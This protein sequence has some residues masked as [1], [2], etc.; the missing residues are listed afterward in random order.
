MKVLQVIDRLNI[1][2]AERVFVNL[3]KLLVGKGIL[4]DA[5]LFQSGYPL[6]SEISRNSR[7]HI[8]NRKNKYSLLK[9]YKA[10]RICSH[11][12]IVHVHMRHC[13]AYIKLAQRL[14]GGRYKIILHDH[15]GDIEID[16]TI[17]LRL[18]VL[19][20]EYYI[21]V[22]N[23]LLKWG[24]YDLKMQPSHAFLLGNTIQPQNG[25]Y[26]SA[27]PAKKAILVSNLRPTK[28][29]EFAIK[30]FKETGWELDIY[31]NKA[32]EH[33]YQKLTELIGTTD[34]IRIIS[35]V[36]DL[37]SVYDQYT[38]AIHCSRSETGPLVLLEYLAYGVPF[39]AYK[40]G[41]VA[42]IVSKELPQ[43]FMD[44]FEPNEWKKRIEEI[45]EMKALPQKQ[46]AIFNKYFSPDAYVQKC[47]EIYRCVHS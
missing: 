31:G 21:G 25:H 13:F 10:H 30:L 35:N 43:L 40:T 42:E 7:V 8:L 45:I 29:I 2:G 16:K 6:E 22:S 26:A 14:F 38:I 1:G 19:K 11:Y 41:E 3:T 4:V 44:S 47:L 33:Y 46:K 20:P 37:S 39:I 27:R 18:K 5:L 28:N 36:T 34:K 9:L 17:L 24:I 23:T 15:Y 32:D 12:D